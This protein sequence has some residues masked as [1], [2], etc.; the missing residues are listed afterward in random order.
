MQLWCEDMNHPQY[1]SLYLLFLFSLTISFT[2]HIK[3]K[4][5]QGVVLLV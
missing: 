5:K 3:E 1:V 2:A 4:E